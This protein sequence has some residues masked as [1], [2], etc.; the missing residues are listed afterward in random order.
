LFGGERIVDR[1]PLASYRFDARGVFTIT[2]ANGQVWQ[3]TDDS[4]LAHWRGPASSYIAS[5][6]KGAAD[7]ANLTIVDDAIYKVRRV[8]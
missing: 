7:T 6:A 4:K 3:Q 1:I 8:Q 2:L 5:I